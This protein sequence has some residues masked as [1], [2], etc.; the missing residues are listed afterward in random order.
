[1][2]LSHDNHNPFP[3][4]AS[5]PP[6]Q[7]CSIK[8]PRPLAAA[9]KS[10]SADDP[11]A[12]SDPQISSASPQYPLSESAMG[13]KDEAETPLF[14][15]CIIMAS[16]FGRR[17]GCNKLLCDLHG[18]PLI[19]YIL[20]TVSASSLSPILVVTRYPEAAEICAKKGIQSL[21]HNLPGRNDTIRL[22]LQRLMASHSNLSG[23]LFCPADQP[24]IH[25]FSLENLLLAFSHMPDRICRLGYK[26]TAGAPV[27]FGRRFFPDLLSL[28]QGKGG[29][30]LL[31]KY[32]GQVTIVPARDAYELYDADTPEELAYLSHLLSASEVS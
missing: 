28:P 3:G 21:L 1:M 11:K 18:K 4:T 14:V 27:L 22:G 5:L 31:K 15:G 10:M 7:P 9:A 20:D 26:D 6:S 30:Y 8:A 29:S 24:L 25:S 16:G 23:C 19:S 17:F 13:G 12:P 32:P 2:F